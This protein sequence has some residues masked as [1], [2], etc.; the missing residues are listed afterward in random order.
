M[1]GTYEH[2]T[3]C[4]GCA[5]EEACAVWLD[6]T[7]CAVW[8]DGTVSALDEWLRSTVR[9]MLN[10]ALHHKP[11]ILNSFKVKLLKLERLQYC[12]AAILG[13]FAN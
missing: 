8:L 12:T 4:Q 1:S 6:G 5:T 13:S 3:A 10:T 2:S 11:S 9:T 7:L